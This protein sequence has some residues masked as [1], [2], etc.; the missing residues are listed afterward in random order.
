MPSKSKSMEYFEMSEE[1]FSKLTKNE[2][3]DINKLLTTTFK[4]RLTRLLNT[5]GGKYSPALNS[6][7]RIA[8]GKKEP[9][10]QKDIS[11][12]K[13]D[14]YSFLQ[15]GDTL[16]KERAYFAQMRQ[17]LYQDV[18]FSM[19][20]WK[21][22]YNNMREY[23]GDKSLTHSQ[24]VDFWQAYD[25][26]LASEKNAAMINYRE[27]LAGV[28]NYKAVWDDIATYLEDGLSVSEIV[29]KMNKKIGEEYERTREAEYADTLPPF[30]TKRKI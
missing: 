18:T 5:E 20:G 23:I 3:S 2:L 7:Y 27:N 24:A 12:I 8:S 25:R 14:I 26:I 15:R 29:E 28:L 13:D 11:E 9:A 10:Y 6:L 17:Y 16:N 19:K 30:I 21:E 1:E 4:R 22:V